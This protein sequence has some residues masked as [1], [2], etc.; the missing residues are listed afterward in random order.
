V[1]LG[2]YIFQMFHCN[3]CLCLQRNIKKPF[4]FFLIEIVPLQMAF[5]KPW[6]LPHFEVTFSAAGGKGSMSYGECAESVGF[7]LT[8]KTFFCSSSRF[9]DSKRYSVSVSIW[10]VAFS[11][12]GDKPTSLY[13]HILHE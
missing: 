10:T 5:N 8:L 12:T 13:T 2:R 4:N 3:F 1:A 11:V 6:V 9:T 7:S